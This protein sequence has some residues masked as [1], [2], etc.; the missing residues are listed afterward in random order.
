MLE[1]QLTARSA[2]SDWTP[3]CQQAAFRQ[4]MNCFAYPGRVNALETE[5]AHALPLLG[6][7]Q[8]NPQK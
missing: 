7:M 6:G 1:Q 3:A 8:K 5:S 2:K 4:I